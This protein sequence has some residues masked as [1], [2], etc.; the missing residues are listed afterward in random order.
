M[1][2]LLFG[3][4]SL[5]GVAVILCSAFQFAAMREHR[6]QV[7]Q[8]RTFLSELEHLETAKSGV[9]LTVPSYASMRARLHAG[10]KLER[11]SIVSGA[12]GLLTFAIGITGFV[13]ESKAYAQRVGS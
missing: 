1:R 4:V 10:T 5:L 2:T 12:L 3:I 8:V 6:R 7:E 13:T 9:R 11:S